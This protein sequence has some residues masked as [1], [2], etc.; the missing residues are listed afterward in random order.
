MPLRGALPA[1]NRQPYT[2]SQNGVLCPPAL[3]M[4]TMNPLFETCRRFETACSRPRGW[5]VSLH[6]RRGGASYGA[7]QN[8]LSVMRE[9]AKK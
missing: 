7:V 4:C 1:N 3:F 6:A 8:E 5:P 2:T 9:S